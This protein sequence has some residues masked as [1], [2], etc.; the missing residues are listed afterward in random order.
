M[1]GN[2]GDFDLQ[3]ESISSDEECFEQKD[4]SALI[5]KDLTSEEMLL[6]IYQLLLHMPNAN[7][8]FQLNSN[9]KKTAKMHLQLFHARQG[10]IKGSKAKGIY[11][12]WWCVKQLY[13][14]A[15][16][17]LALYEHITKEAPAMVWLS[18]CFLL[19]NII[20]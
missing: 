14:I 17:S 11:L 19:K 4:V 10:G 15:P 2:D 3:F 12:G 8:T 5:E 6:Q 20:F 16:I 1:L 7:D 18:F 9:N 13:K